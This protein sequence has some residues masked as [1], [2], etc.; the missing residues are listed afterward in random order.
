MKDYARQLLFIFL[1]FL[2]FFPV[3][4]QAIEVPNPLEWD[5]VAELIYALID[6]IF[7][8]AVVIAPLMIIVAGFY[9]VTAGQNPAQINTAK[10]II[11]WTLVGLL[12]TISAKGIIELFKITFGI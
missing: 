9:F 6:V 1:S 4:T 10:Q 12:I 5:S 8:L 2:L 7:T 3:L 11:L